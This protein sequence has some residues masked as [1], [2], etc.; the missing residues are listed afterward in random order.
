[1]ASLAQPLVADAVVDGMALFSAALVAYL[2][3]LLI[4]EKRKQCKLLN[5]RER[6]RRNHWVTSRVGGRT[7]LTC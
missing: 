2:I 6:S 4:H 1:M 3:R 7:I 5:A